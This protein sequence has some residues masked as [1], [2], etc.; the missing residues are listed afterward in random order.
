MSSIL[1]QVAVAVGCSKASSLN[2]PVV[3]GGLAADPN[4]QHIGPAPDPIQLAAAEIALVVADCH[5]L[6]AG[7]PAD[8][9]ALV[10]AEPQDSQVV[11]AANCST[12]LQGARPILAAKVQVVPIAEV[13]PT[14]V[15]VAVPT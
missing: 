5:C 8:D 6:K 2:T 14:V 11:V 3:A 1:D 13:H 12:R 10:A 7:L 4:R 15:V 9:A